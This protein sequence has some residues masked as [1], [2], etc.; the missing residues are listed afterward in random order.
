MSQSKPHRSTIQATTKNNDIGLDRFRS[1]HYAN[2]YFLLWPQT[3]ETAAKPD[4]FPTGYTQ[5]LPKGASDLTR[6]PLDH[7]PERQIDH[8]IGERTQILSVLIPDHAPW[9]IP[10]KPADSDIALTKNGFSR[11]PRLIKKYAQ[12][13][14]SAKIYAHF[15][16]SAPFRLW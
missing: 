14:N 10:I 11:A 8:P 3:S 5:K 16:F 15:V 7:K 12:I 4:H 2:P 1:I 9:V 6:G 13:L